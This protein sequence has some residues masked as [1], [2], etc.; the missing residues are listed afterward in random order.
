MARRK[1]FT[2]EQVSALQPKAKRYTFP[3][4]EQP[5]LYVRVQP[6][7]S[8]SFVVVT[9][10][11]KKWHTIG[12]TA[13]YTIADARDRA[14]KIIQAARDGVAAPESFAAIADKW[15]EMHV[16]RK[17][18][19]SASV[20]DLHLRRLKD[21]FVGRD[22][23]SIKRRD[24]AN[25]LDKLA[26]ENGERAADYTLQVFSGVANWYATRDDD[27][28]SPIVRGMTRRNQKESARK[29]ILNDDEIRAVWKAA[30]A[31]G[32]FGAMVRILLLTGQRRE[33]VA[34]MKWEHIEGDTW[35]IPT[36]PREKGNAGELV[37]PQVALDIINAQP[38]F[39]DN[40]YVFAGRGPKHYHAFSNGKDAL[41]AKLP[42]M[43]QWGLHDLR[44][45]A[46]SLMARAGVR[47]D[48]AE[49]VLGHAIPGVQGVYNRFE[50]RN[51]KA[52]ALKALASMIESILNPKAESN[53]RRLALH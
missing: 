28:T 10:G 52:Q 11:G 6:S 33:K 32:T 41:E 46:R 12:D 21:E 17:G 5:C 9:Q 30:A 4:P 49:Q 35:N 31:N 43:P 39:T 48:H 3:D 45:T 18:L 25:L 42:D 29:R 15:R 16:Q 24:L 51:E 36:A 44:R 40:P 23:T 8:K 19:R 34:T 38:R 26:K 7:G 37:L 20:I 27:Y 14:R 2:D 1:R 53:V 47:D 50:Y 22:F 13:T